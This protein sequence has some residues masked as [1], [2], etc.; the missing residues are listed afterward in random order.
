MAFRAL[1]CGWEAARQ[2][3][4]DN[5]FKVAVVNIKI[6]SPWFVRVD[7]AAGETL[8]FG[9]EGQSIQIFYIGQGFDLA[10]AA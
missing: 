4:P 1:E 5:F 6:E 10:A 9:T 2:G 7:E 8:P 3:W